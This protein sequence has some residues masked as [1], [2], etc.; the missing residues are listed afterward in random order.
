[1]FLGVSTAV[2]S[3]GRVK[4][5]VVVAGFWGD[6]AV[7]PVFVWGGCWGWGEAVEE[8]EKEE[9]K[10]EEWGRGAGLGGEASPIRST[11]DALAMAAV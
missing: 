3:V 9:L 10:M 5:K 11:V 2:M 7:T 4:A 8:E 1:M 6:M